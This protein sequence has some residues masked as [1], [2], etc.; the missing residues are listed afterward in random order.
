MIRDI[1]L[2]QS[3]YIPDENNAE[4]LTILGQSG[5]DLLTTL[6]HNVNPNTDEA[7]LQMSV[8]YNHLTPDVLEAFKQLSRQEVTALL[9]RLNTWLAEHNGVD[10]NNTPNA[11]RAGLGI[12]YFQDQQDKQ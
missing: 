4:K 10:T 11:H 7:Y 12:Y 3:G 5:C 1:E 8:A 6:E 2:K 9:L